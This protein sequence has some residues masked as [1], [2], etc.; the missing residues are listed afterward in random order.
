M[1]FWIEL[2]TNRLFITV[3]FTAIVVNIL[4][5]I[6]SSIRKGKLDF[7]LMFLTGGMPSSHTAV[8]IA[9][10]TGV[11]YED[12]IGPLAIVAGTLAAVVIYDALTLRRAVGIQSELLN[13]LI[14]K[15]N[16]KHQKKLREL[17]GHSIWEAI[18][19]A[20]VGY[21]LAYAVYHL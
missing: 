19:G 16:F 12:G 4:K 2:I 20:I 8:V 9:L 11:Y 6:V 17:L 5:V 3:V 15:L 10:T 21:A 18:V 1:G 14:K 7:S 13:K